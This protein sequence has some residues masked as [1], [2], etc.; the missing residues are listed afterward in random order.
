[1][2]RKIGITMTLL[3]TLVFLAAMLESGSLMPLAFMSSLTASLAIGAAGM[4]CLAGV[5]SRNWRLAVIRSA[6]TRR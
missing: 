5:V 6:S 4:I 1:M 3:G 2:L